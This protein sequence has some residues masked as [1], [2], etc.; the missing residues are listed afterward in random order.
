[1]GELFTNLD[2]HLEEVTCR[3]CLK[4]FRNPK[5]LPCLH[6]FCLS[7]LN[8]RYLPQLQFNQ[9]T[10]RTFYQL[11]QLIECPICRYEIKI[12]RDGFESLPSSLYI[13]RLLDVLAIKNCDTSE[14]KC[15][16]CGTTTKTNSYCFECHGFLCKRKCLRV[17]NAV[18]TKTRHRVLALQNFRHEDYEAFMKSASICPQ[19]HHK[20]ETLKLFCKQCRACTCQICARD[21][22][23]LHRDQLVDLDVAANELRTRMENSVKKSREKEQVL[24]EIVR[25]MKQNLDEYEDK[26]AFAKRKIDKFSEELV[27]QIRNDDNL[28]KNIM[29]CYSSSETKIRETK[30]EMEIFKKFLGKTKV[31]MERC[32]NAE[33]FSLVQN[34][35]QR[36]NIM[37]KRE[38]ECQSLL[39]SV[40]TRPTFLLKQKV[41]G[42]VNGKG[43]D[44]QRQEI[45]LDKIT[46]LAGCFVFIFACSL[47]LLFTGTNTMSN[48]IWGVAL[49]NKSEII[50]T[51]FWDHHLRIFKGDIF[52]SHHVTGETVGRKGRGCQEFACPLGLAI[53]DKNDIFVA[54]RNNHRIVVLKEGMVYSNSFGGKGSSPGQLL[55]PTGVSLDEDE[56]IIISDTGNHR[57]QVFSKRGR[58]ILN[59]GDSREGK[60]NNPVQCVSIRGRFFVSEIQEYNIKVY[61]SKGKFLFKFAEQSSIYKLYHQLLVWFNIVDPIPPGHSGHT[62]RLTVDVNRDLLVVTNPVTYRVQHFSVDGILEKTFWTIGGSSFAVA[63]N[64]RNYITVKNFLE[65]FQVWKM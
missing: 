4:H 56:N 61:D 11:V 20:R 6:N 5:Q 23:S 9:Y 52:S 2:D 7:C 37:I 43:E 40:D 57:I 32:T 58:L 46:L 1:M 10:D 51:D 25:K 17:H 3:L 26:D 31:E 44:V 36:L 41:I 15:G 42:S 63:M 60:L 47:Q 8:S 59:F 29:D 48:S 50:V 64:S 22:H 27:T 35:E 18:K 55:H 38:S 24:A 19:T 28:V 53:T 16:D 45:H 39:D 30:I 12:P 13:T 49:N 34:L 21:E 65:K 62:Y 14:L 54:D 33:V